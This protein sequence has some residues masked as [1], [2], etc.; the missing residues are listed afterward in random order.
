MLNIFKKKYGQNGITI[1][2]NYSNED[3]VMTMGRKNVTSQGIP[4]TFFIPIHSYNNVGLS[5]FAIVVPDD[6]CTKW[7]QQ[8]LAL[9]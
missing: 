2:Y 8:T 5:L 3:Y 6:R 1:V 7:S 9:S 4:S